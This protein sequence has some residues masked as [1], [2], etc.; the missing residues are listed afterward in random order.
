MTL[1]HC[2]IETLRQFSETQ[3]CK[4][5]RTGDPWDVMVSLASHGLLW[6]EKRDGYYWYGIWRRKPTEFWAGLTTDG[7]QALKE[8]K[9]S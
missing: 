7:L 6:V 9:A 1:G 2:Q 3:K 8:S 5:K 4:P